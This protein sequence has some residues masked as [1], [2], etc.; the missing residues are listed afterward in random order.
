[1]ERY[2]GE[3]IARML[4]DKGVTACDGIEAEVSRLHQP[5]QQKRI[6]RVAFGRNS[7][8]VGP[9]VSTIV[10]AIVGLILGLGVGFRVRP[11]V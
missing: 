8:T 11:I 3:N 10:S 5:R 2:G 1:M 4:L 9:K 6:F 7:V